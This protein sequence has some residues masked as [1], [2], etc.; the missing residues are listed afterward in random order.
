MIP[1]IFLSIIDHHELQLN[2]FKV[3]DS[4][5]EYVKQNQNTETII[6]LLKK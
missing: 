4:K 1:H 3:Y 2:I 5:L 6:H